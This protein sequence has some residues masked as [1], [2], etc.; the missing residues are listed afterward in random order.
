[1]KSSDKLLKYVQVQ[2]QA[3]SEMKIEM[4]NNYDFFKFCNFVLIGERTEV[5]P[6]I[7]ID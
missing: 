1:M 2:V 7:G 3:L 5:T 4:L 6:M